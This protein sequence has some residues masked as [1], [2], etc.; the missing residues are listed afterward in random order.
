MLIICVMGIV[1]V[2]WGSDYA[3]ISI[4]VH[5]ARV[6]KS[7]IKKPCS[8][9]LAFVLAIS[10]VWDRNQDERLCLFVCL[11]VCFSRPTSQHQK[12][13]YLCRISKGG[14]WVLAEKKIHKPPSMKMLS[15]NLCMKTCTGTYVPEVKFYAWFGRVKI[16]NSNRK[17]VNRPTGFRRN[18]IFHNFHWKA[19]LPCIVIFHYISTKWIT[20]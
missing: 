9:W 5:V 13:G 7:V 20:R 17:T 8:S 1:C 3:V 10:H 12:K 18:F 4:D 2:K 11:F 16:V 15:F 14:I 6:A 19:L